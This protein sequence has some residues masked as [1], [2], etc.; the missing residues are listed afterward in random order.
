MVPVAA[1]FT[2][3]ASPGRTPAPGSGAHRFRVL[4]LVTRLIVGGAQEHAI[5][6]AANLDPTRYDSQLWTG[7]ETGSEGSLLEDAR[8]RGV[9]VRI[10]PDLVR[11]IDPP[12]DARV[13]L[14]LAR[15]FRRERF[16]LVSTHSS[17]A[18]IVG[19]IAARMAGV[20]VVVHTVHGWGF[21]E[22]MPPGTKRAYEVLERLLAPGTHT[23]ASVSER[24]TRTGLEAGIGRPEQYV[25]VR[26]G[27]PLGAF[28]PDPETGR[29]VRAAFGWDDG[30]RV[31]GSVGRL[32]PQKNPVDFVRAARRIADAHPCA[33]FLYVGDG[34]LR[35]AIEAQI[36][37][38][39]LGDRVVLAGLRNDV[40]ELLRAMDVFVLTSLWEGMP[41]VVLQALATGVPVVSY[42]IAGIAEAVRDDR[43]GFTVAAGDIAAVAGRVSALLSDDALRQAL[44]RRA[45]D[46]FDES[47][48]EEGMLRRLD[49]LYSRLLDAR[50]VRMAMSPGGAG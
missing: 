33:R 18:G 45:V 36:A 30:I 1:V 43:N 40:P 11:R 38:A 12:R 39:G 48:T 14:E 31:V 26:S 10:I 29:R 15:L 13:T 8:R 17:K 4:Q 20:P 49:E 32:S 21:H 28:R 35:P 46:E 3:E 24:T 7:P 37:A 25:L 41:R 27:V 22:H 23:L 34:P 16:D 2:D 19:R 42:D 5:A 44:G 6:A 9:N 50:G 47:F